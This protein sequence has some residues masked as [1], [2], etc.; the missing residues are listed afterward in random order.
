MTN[1]NFFENAELIYAYT[2]EQGL[3]D[4][5]YEHV[6]PATALEAGY[7]I[8]VLLTQPAYAA[9]VQWTRDPGL[10]SE[11]ARFWDLLT[12]ARRAAKDACA[13]PGD[14]FS[15]SV[16]RVENTTPNG[17]QSTSETA[18]MQELKIV[19]QAYNLTGRGCLIVA[20]P[21]ED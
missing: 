5:I 9:A 21:D 12:V 6:S 14:P 11:D 17:E 10:Q 18:T 16:L 8:P 19:A 13:S 3:A 2:A 15:F 20:L 4:G 1:Q 7:R